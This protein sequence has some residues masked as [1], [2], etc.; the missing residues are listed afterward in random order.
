M[1]CIRVANRCGLWSRIMGGEERRGRSGNEQVR[2]FHGTKWSWDS[3]P[4]T[5]SGDAAAAVCI[6][7]V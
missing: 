1:I 4:T 3:G 5:K 7:G 6:K 2:R